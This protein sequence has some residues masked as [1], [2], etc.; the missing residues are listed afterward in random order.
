MAV[1]VKVGSEEGYSLLHSIDEI[2]MTIGRGEKITIPSGTTFEVDSP[3][4]LQ[5]HLV[6]NGVLKVD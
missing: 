6:L 3:F 1:R 5:G 4:E 2:S